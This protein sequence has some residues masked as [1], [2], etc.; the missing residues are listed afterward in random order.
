M[1]TYFIPF[2][3]L[4]DSNNFQDIED[5]PAVSHDAAG[6]FKK[7]EPCVDSLLVLQKD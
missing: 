2:Q 5:D 1:D 4:A 6:P 7:S 3:L